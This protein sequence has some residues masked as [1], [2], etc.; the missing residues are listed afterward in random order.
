M[1]HQTT[2]HTSPT[3]L[4]YDLETTGLNP[5][6]DQILQF[7]A[8]RTDTA[9]NELERLE[10][11]VRLRPDVIPSPGALLV[12]GVSTLRAME[13]VSEYEAI[14]QIH[15]LVNQRGTI[16]LG[17]NSLSFDDQ[18]LRFAFYRNLLPAYT[19][20]WLDGCKRLDL[21]P[22]TVLYWLQESPLLVWPQHNERA[23]L[24]LEFL[25]QANGLSDGQAHDALVDVAATVELARRL[26]RE[27]AFWQACLVHF[28]KDAH[29]HQVQTLP[30]FLNRP[31]ALLVE[32]KFGYDHACQVP[33][34]YLGKTTTQAKR[35]LWLR[36]DHDKLSQA[37]PD[38]LAE[39]TRVV[40]KKPGEPAFIVDPKQHKLT[41]E[42]QELTRANLKWLQQ[43]PDLL[44][45]IEAHHLSFQYPEIP[46]VDADAALYSNGFPSPEE[47]ALCREFH[48][49]PLPQKVRLIS[50]FEDP[51]LRELAVRLLCRN[52]NL[53]YRFPE[54]ATYRR[55]LQDE[56]APLLDYR[57]RARLTPGKAL[58]DIARLRQTDNLEKNQWA[59]LSD[60]EKYVRY[61]FGNDI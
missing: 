9:F 34:L 40:S 28:N 56:E 54:Y 30:H 37:T 5:A 45:A 46:S 22:I 12:T 6:F 3:Y 26:Y 15:A 33:V 47:E 23:T 21:F 14:R 55:Q 60:L 59:I 25:N 10:I 35:T 57:G 17:Y 2:M 53:A 13:G 18:F 31:Y 44:T 4:F 36:L 39:T 58:A 16:N 49:S 38:N 61:Q 29:A 7:A 19:H 1:L 48:Q 27:Q 41:P 52:F 50:Q 20:Q 32:G 43:N 8:I 42:R 24:K 11:R 51:I